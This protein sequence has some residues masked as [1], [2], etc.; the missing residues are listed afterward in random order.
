MC[1]PRFVAAM[2]MAALIS[3]G[4]LIPV[5]AEVRSLTLDDL[6]AVGGFGGANADP[7]GRWLV[8]ERIRPYEEMEDFSYRNYAFYHSGHQLWRYDPKR[9]GLPELLPGLDPEPSSYQQG[10]SASGRY[11]AVMQYQ[12]GELKLGAY[13]MQHER[14]VRFPQT[15]AFSRY[16]G[17]YSPVW[18]SDNEIVF[19][20]MPEGQQPYTNQRAHSGRVLARAW[21]D[22][23]RG[24]VTTAS[25]IRTPTKDESDQQDEGSLVRADART[26]E[27]HILAEGLFAD[28]RASPS[29]GHLA[30]LTRSRPRLGRLSDVTQHRH[31]LTVFD[32]RSGSSRLLAPHLEF[33]PYSIAWA[34]DG[35]RLAAYGWALGDNP[36]NGRFYVIDVGSGA[37]TRYDHLGLELA[38]ERERGM[39]RRP[40]RVLFLGDRL[41]VFAR[42]IPEGEDQTPRFTYQDIRPTHLSKADWFAL[43]SDGTATNLT[44]GIPGVSGIPVHSGVG[45][46][47]V[48]APDGV[49]RLYADGK[50]RRLT[51]KLPGRYR[52]MSP[53][54]FATPP[55]AIRPEFS[56]EALFDV[57]EEHWAKVV[58]V[59]LRD[60][61]EGDVLVVDAPSG[62]ASPLAGS[63]RSAAVL[64]AAEVKPVSRLFVANN[65]GG[66]VAGLREIDQ[67]N[68]HLAGIEFGRRQAVSY[69]VKDAHGGT[70]TIESCV[71]LPPGHTPDAPP[72][73][74]IAEVYPHARS[75]CEEEGATISL[76]SLYS[77]PHLWAARG[78][79]YSMLTLPRSVIRSDEGPIAGMPEAVNAGIGALVSHGLADPQKIALLGR[80]QGGVSALY[81]SAHTNRFKAVIANHSWANLF[82]HY[83]GGNGIHSYVYGGYFGDAMRYDNV[84]GSDFGIGRTPFEDPDVYIRNS[85]V[86]LAPRI[87]APVMLIHS[88]MDGFSM[89]QF[90][91]MFGALQRAEKDVRYVR[92]WGEGHA[93]SSPANIRDMWERMDSFLKEA[94][95]S[96]RSSR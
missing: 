16:D 63:V 68:N 70:H 89:S 88:D 45:H 83:F 1:P 43:G 37:V 52:A 50:R 38:D 49:Y 54:T 87:N 42:Q 31:H 36:N 44:D 32:L 14:M 72:P 74:L 47:T 40:E 30:A 10:F 61:Q 58:M 93:P 25:E 20:A 15:P 8:Y 21:N 75:D 3:I 92:Y 53:G 28:L 69:E 59:D 60:G 82:S 57:S 34:P 78:Y 64:F 94:G 7:T 81:V 71:F 26:G 2:A 76:L 6:M 46:L 18:I 56:D 65:S 79:A 95:V 22:A 66:E 35:E 96:P 29:G 73:P 41:A 67:I 90:D 33:W 27:T 17:L 84:A 91:E 12:L 80:S 19:V 85:P 9:G 11:L 62:N 5:S 86:F 24:K 39:W 23:W 13:D 55:L 48:S 4:S 51:P 77:S